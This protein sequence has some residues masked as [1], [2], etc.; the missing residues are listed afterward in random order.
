MWETYTWCARRGQHLCYMHANGGSRFLLPLIGI[1]FVIHSTD[2]THAGCV[3]CLIVALWVCC[4]LPEL[5]HLPNA[6]L[7]RPRMMSEWCLVGHF[8]GF[9]KGQGERRY[10]W[11]LPVGRQDRAGNV[12]F[13][14]RAFLPE[15]TSMLLALPYWKLNKASTLLQACCSCG[16]ILLLD[17]CNVLYGLPGYEP[18]S[19]CGCRG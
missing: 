1:L 15:H 2:V 18:R 11:K 4:T 17:L 14:D 8:V 10:C 12:L 7:D 6:T 9:N 13:A 19:W 3:P 5:Q 16:V